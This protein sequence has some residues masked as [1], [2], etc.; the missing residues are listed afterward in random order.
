MAR[1]PQCNGTGVVPAAQEERLRLVLEWMAKPTGAT[2]SKH[3]TKRDGRDLYRGVGTR[4][5]FLMNTPLSLA[6]WL[7]MAEVEVLTL[8]ER[9][10]VVPTYPER[11]N[12]CLSLPGYEWCPRP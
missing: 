1:C 10:L 11:G 3:G 5:W 4:T 9:A 8:V 7:P 6:P 12:E 2:P